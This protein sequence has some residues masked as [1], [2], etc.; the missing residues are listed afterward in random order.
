MKQAITTSIILGAIYCA[1]NPAQANSPFDCEKLLTKER[2]NTSE[3]PEATEGLPQAATSTRD[4][5]AGN[6]IGRLNKSS[7]RV[8]FAELRVAAVDG[9][10]SYQLWSGGDTPLHTTTSISDLLEHIE[11]R[12][13][14]LN[15]TASHLDTSSLTPAQNDGLAAAMR[16]REQR[17]QRLTRIIARS[18]PAIDSPLFERGITFQFSDIRRADGSFKVEARLGTKSGEFRVTVSAKARAV[19]ERFIAAVRKL[20]GQPR[21][22]TMTFIDIINEARDITGADEKDLQMLLDG[23]FGHSE[24]VVNIIPLSVVK[25]PLG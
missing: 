25:R 17:R 23:Q 15:K 22:Q 12:A 3:T 13:K 18:H 8:L 14:A 24:F 2:T 11:A 16:I 5:G 1:P 6:R 9:S 19:L 10:V 21:S 4:R 7:D 20:L